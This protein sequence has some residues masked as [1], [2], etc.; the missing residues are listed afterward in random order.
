MEYNCK[1][2]YNYAA[3]YTMHVE[4]QKD[5]VEVKGGTFEM[6]RT[7]LACSAP[8]MASKQSSTTQTR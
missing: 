6:N 2:Q 8:W 4:M 3:S 7:M 1:R 5:Q